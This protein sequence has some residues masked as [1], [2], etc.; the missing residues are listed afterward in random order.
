MEVEL[1]R[2]ISKAINDFGIVNVMVSLVLALS[3]GY[4][5]RSKTK[6]DTMLKKA[7]EEQAKTSESAID[8]TN[9][10]LV[11]IQRTTIQ[12][13]EVVQM[14]SGQIQGALAI[15]TALTQRDVD[16]ESRGE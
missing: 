16:R 8:R 6:S 15:I 14:L 3:I 13:L 2:E 9:D 4:Y 5:L 7:L 11:E 10:A 1:F 12:V